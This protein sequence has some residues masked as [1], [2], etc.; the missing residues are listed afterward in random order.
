MGTVV[1][2]RTSGAAAEDAP[3]L[4]QTGLLIQGQAITCCRHS[5]SEP[6]T[7]SGTGV[8][9]PLGGLKRLPATLRHVGEVHR[10]AGMGCRIVSDALEGQQG[11]R[12]LL[13][14]VYHLQ[15]ASLMYPGLWGQVAATASTEQP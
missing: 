4:L 12:V 8:V 3:Q 14:A 11:V 10:L 1:A 9:G 6:G 15:R 7:S 13:K 2:P 5:R